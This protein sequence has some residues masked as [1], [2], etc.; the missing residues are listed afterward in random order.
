MCEHLGLSA[1]TGTRMRGDNNSAV[2]E[3][4]L[5]YN[6]SSGFD[7]FSILASNSNEFNRDHPPL[8]K[9]RHSLPFELFDD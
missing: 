9:N 1:L 7:D 3:Q 4:H 2:K 5:F 6:H 8:N